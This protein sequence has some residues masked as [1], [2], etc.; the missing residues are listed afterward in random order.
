MTFGP[1]IKTEA[2][3][4]CKPEEVF[5]EFALGSECLMVVKITFEITTADG[6]A[7]VVHTNASVANR[8]VL[9]YPMLVGRRDLKGG[10]LVDPSIS[11]YSKKEAEE[12]EKY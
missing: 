3:N 2:G 1:F 7:I 9:R 8:K 11:G 10:F 6:S 12:K 4:H 5:V